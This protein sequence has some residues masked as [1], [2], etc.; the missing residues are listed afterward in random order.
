MNIFRLFELR[1]YNNLTEEDV[2]NILGV[3]Q[4]T[5]SA[6]ETERKVIP[7]KH[8]ITLCKYYKVSLDYLTGLDNNKNGF[9][10]YV[11][12]DKVA[13]GKRI[14]HIRELNHLKQKVLAKSLNT[15]PS[16]ISAYENGHNL[17]ITAFAYQICRDYKVSFDWLVG[18]KET[19]KKDL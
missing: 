10:N 2:A 17:I 19:I 7:L 18:A 3:K 4:Q 1:E 5:Y 12:L 11:T 14:K 16:T 15:S 6:Y 13:I 8:L 9:Y